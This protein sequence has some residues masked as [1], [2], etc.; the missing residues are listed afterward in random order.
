[1]SRTKIF[2]SYSHTDEEWRKRIATHLRVL[3]TQGVLEIRD[4]TQIQVGEKWFDRIDS[5]LSDARVAVLLVSAEFLTSEF[6]VGKEVPALLKRHHQDGL[7][8]VPIILRPCAWKE[9]DW[10]ARMQVRPKAGRPLSSGNE[11]QIDQDCSEL[12]KELNDIIGSLLTEV[13]NIPLSNELFPQGLRLLEFLPDRRLVIGSIDQEDFFAI[14]NLARLVGCV[15]LAYFMCWLFGGG[16]A[17]V[18]AIV[19]GLTISWWYL[20]HRWGQVVTIDIKRYFYIINWPF[21]GPTWPFSTK[22]SSVQ[23]KDENDWVTSVYVDDVVIWRVRSK[24]PSTAARKVGPF[25]SAL[26]AIANRQRP[27]KDAS[28][29]LGPSAIVDQVEGK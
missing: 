7:V 9:V 2:I 10:L 4:D 23:D 25:V 6:I 29:T 26:R 22:V 16:Y 18:Y 27:H 21:K 1:M 15:G 17:I 8:I 24:D 28:G 3:E 14:E 5:E 12:A 13:P 11:H 19:I 20:T